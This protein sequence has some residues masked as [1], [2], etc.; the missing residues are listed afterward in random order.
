MTYRRYIFHVKVHFD[1]ESGSY[2]SLDANL[3]RNPSFQIKA[4]NLEKVLKV[5][6]I[7]FVLACHLQK[8]ADPDPAYHFSADL[9]ADPKPQ[10]WWRR[11][12]IP[13]PY[14]G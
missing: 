11:S 8:D 1:A 5:A 14:I 2:L 9:Y 10:H 13:V 6:H 4:Q 3:D 12:P 7:L